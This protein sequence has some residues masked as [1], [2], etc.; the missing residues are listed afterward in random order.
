MILNYANIRT[1]RPCRWLRR[2]AAAVYI[3]PLGP[4]TALRK[5]KSIALEAVSWPY[6]TDLRRQ[7]LFYSARHRMHCKS[8]SITTCTNSMQSL[9][10]HSSGILPFPPFNKA[11]SFFAVK[12]ILP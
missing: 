6:M 11:C 2:Y 3:Q 9:S 4:S 1:M 10:M 7:A 12:V 8:A 5:V